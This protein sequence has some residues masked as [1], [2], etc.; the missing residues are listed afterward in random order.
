VNRF[1]SQAAEIEELV[2]E[3]KVSAARGAI[4]RFLIAQR[5]SHE[6]TFM[7][8]D[9]FR[10]L[11]LYVEGYRLVAPRDPLIRATSTRTDL[12][13]QAL[14]AARFLNLQGAP[15]YAR[16]LLQSLKLESEEDHWIAGNIHLVDFDYERSLP[17]LVRMRELSLEPNDYRSRL[18]AL[19]VADAYAGSRQLAKALEIAED[20]V[21]ASTEPLLL[22]IAHQTAGEYLARAGEFRAALKRL[23]RARGYFP[24]GESSADYAVFAKWY[25]YASG[26]CGQE[27]RA[28][29]NFALAE[30]LLVGMRLRPESWLDI[31]RLRME[32]GFLNQT[33]SKHLLHFPGLSKGFCATLPEV[34]EVATFGRAGSPI[35]IDFA[36]EEYRIRD[37]RFLGLTLEMKLLGWIRL[38]G[39]WGLN[40]M[41]AKGLL[42]PDD[43]Y[44]YLELEGRMHQLLLRLRKTH[45]INITLN[46]GRLSLSIQEHR[47]I[48]VLSGP[49]TPPT[50]LT[51]RD[52]MS[53]SELGLYYGLRKSQ[54]SEV[55]RDWLN[56]GWVKAQGRGPS[57]RYRTSINDMQSRDHIG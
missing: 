7:A 25:G 28:R 11:G 34:R 51:S 21:L 46:D 24:P 38:A 15:E 40:L 32:L 6:A 49:A 54:R 26:R 44:S 30:K 47:K 43:V 39:P 29:E 37:Q 57:T 4:S 14:W 1:Q 31:Y 10:R 36:S 9:W 52:E 20:V 2:R 23:E 18:R 55:L 56:R 48:Q 27:K 53:S 45:G 12:G 13:R 17:L 8:C 19:S 3:R 22:G 41:K 5:K 35:A 16:L 42:W 50:L 33:M